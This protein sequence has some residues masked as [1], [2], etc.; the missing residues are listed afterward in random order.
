MA[1]AACPKCGNWNEPLVESGMCLSCI[2][3]LAR[4]LTR[5]GNLPL[6]RAKLLVAGIALLGYLCGPAYLGY[7]GV[8]GSH[9]KGAIIAE[10][11]EVG[12]LFLGLGFCEHL[13]SRI[14]LLG[15]GFYT[16]VTC[17][18]LVLS[19][20]SQPLIVIKLGIVAM[21]WHSAYRAYQSRKL[22]RAENR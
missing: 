19:S 18:S 6:R 7:D 11:L 4:D 10:I 14:S 13:H 12:L 8:F 16:I 15:F 3:D 22:E 2:R 1:K 21:F 5:T 9:E 20:N 17:G